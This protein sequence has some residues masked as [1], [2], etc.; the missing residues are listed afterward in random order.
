MNQIVFFYFF[1]E[2]VNRRRPP[3]GSPT[4]GGQSLL[5][6]LARTAFDGGTRRWV[7]HRARTRRIGRWVASTHGGQALRR[8]PVPKPA[9]A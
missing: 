4:A 1:D 3:L 8:F 5:P 6:R 9:E 2:M 7:R